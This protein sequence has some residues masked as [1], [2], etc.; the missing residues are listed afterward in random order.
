MILHPQQTF[1]QVR[2][3]LRVILGLYLLRH[4]LVRLPLIATYRQIMG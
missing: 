1:I 3:H 4:L 2:P